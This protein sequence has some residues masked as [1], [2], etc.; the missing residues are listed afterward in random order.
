MSVKL[1][2]CGSSPNSREPMHAKMK[3]YKIQR[4]ENVPKSFNI[5]TI[6]LSIGPKV[7][8]NYSIIRTLNQ[9]KAATT[10]SRKFILNQ[11]PSSSSS[12]TTLP[13]YV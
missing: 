4:I 1:A 12:R 10:A 2:Y 3:S 11:P 7:L 13:P 5:D 9:K 6:I 8:V